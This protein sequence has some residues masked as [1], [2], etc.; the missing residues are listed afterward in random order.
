MV[1]CVLTS[2]A[3]H[4][5]RSALW[6]SHTVLTRAETQTFINQLISLW[7]LF[8]GASD[9]VQSSQY[10]FRLV[11]V[12]TPKPFKVALTTDQKKHRLCMRQVYNSCVDGL[13]TY[14]ALYRTCC[15]QAGQQICHE[16]A[17]IAKSVTAICTV[18]IVN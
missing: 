15:K 2:N 10:T 12:C 7:F 3:I 9:F 8:A 13:C 4:M 6:I 1:L 14:Q 5:Q 17:V 16:E 11:Q 18:C